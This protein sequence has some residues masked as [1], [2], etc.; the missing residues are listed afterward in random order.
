MHGGLPFCLLAL[1]RLVD[2]PTLGRGLVL[3]LVLF[4]QALSCAYYGIFAGLLVGARHDLLR[5]G[6]WDV[7]LAGATGL[8]IGPRPVAVGSDAAVL[9]AVP[10][11]AEG[12]RLRALARRRRDVLGELAGVAHVGGVGASLVAA[13]A[14][15]LDE[16]LFPGLLTHVLGVGGLALAFRERP[17]RRC[18]T[19]ARNAGFYALF[20]DRRV[21]G[22]V[23]ALG[24]ALHGALPH[25]P[26]VL[27]PAR[28]GALRHRRRPARCIVGTG[29][30]GCVGRRGGGRLR[31]HAISALMA[32]ADG[33][34]TR[35]DAARRCPRRRRSTRRTAGWRPRGR[36]PVVEFP[37]FY[38][39]SDFPRHAEYM[40]Y[41]TYHWHAAG[42]RLQRPH[43]AGVPRHGDP[44]VVVPDDGELRDPRS[45][46]RALR[47]V[48]P[49]LLRPAQPARS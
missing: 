18:R 2:R 45:R 32:V 43:P 26:G 4:A 37:F 1:H 9:P 46:R 29:V 41:S 5:A 12:G 44:A 13:V 40:L 21:L 24:R 6:A 33:R 28:A 25:D 39:R 30:R 11:R 42:Q 48:P 31:S 17:A 15:G 16:V 20:A 49:Q 3:G 23:R 8:A 38:D 35:D 27:V 7:A 22:V 14:R 36:A 47:G 19:R 10:R 34:R